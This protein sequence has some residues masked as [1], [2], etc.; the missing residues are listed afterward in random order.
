MMV[1]MQI[2][3]HKA[4]LSLS[5]SLFK[6]SLLLIKGCLACAPNDLKREGQ[7]KRSSPVLIYSFHSWG[8]I[9]ADLSLTESFPLC[10]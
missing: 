1:L 3:Q 9:A 6:S 2:S 5:L 10:K 8:G 7:I 4:T